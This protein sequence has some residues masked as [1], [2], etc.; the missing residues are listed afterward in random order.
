MKKHISLLV[1]LFFTIFSFSQETDNSDWEAHFA[2]VDFVDIEVSDENVY[3][4]AAN[5]VFA[6][7]IETETNTEYTTVDGLSGE[8]ITAI[9]YNS[10]TSTIIIGY[11]NG[12]LQLVN[13]V[14]GNVDTFVDIRE[15]P[16]PAENLKIN[17][18]F[19]E[20]NTLYIASGFGVIIFNLDTGFF[21]NT[22]LISDSSDIISDV[23]SVGVIDNNILVS[24]EGEGTF[25]GDTNNQNLI[26]FDNWS[27]I[28][29][30]VF[31]DIQNFSNNLVAHN[32][33][34]DLFS[35]DGTVFSIEYINSLPILNLEINSSNELTITDA[36]N[37][38]VIDND[39]EELL[40]V[41][42][43]EDL[44][45]DNS[46]FLDNV[47]YF[48]TADTGFNRTA[49]ISFDTFSKI[50]PDGPESNRA[51]AIDAFNN[52]LW[53]TFGDVSSTF[54]VGSLTRTGISRKEGQNWVGFSFE[55]VL[56]VS[57]ITG[58]VIDKNREDHVYF[59]S[60]FGGLLEFNEEDFTLYNSEN[61][62]I[63][64]DVSIDIFPNFQPVRIDKVF[65]STIDD[66][67]NVW[68]LNSRTT[69]PIK[70]FS[71]N[72]N[73]LEVDYSSVV[74]FEA[75]DRDISLN[76]WDIVVSDDGNVFAGSFDRGLIAYN[77][78]RSQIISLNEIEQN[79]IPFVTVR[80][81]ELD[82]NGE[83]WFGTNLGLRR[84]VNP[85][86]IFINGESS[87]A[88]SIIF[89]ENGIA[90]ELLIGQLI[91]DIEVDVNN[92]K[93]I[94]T[95]EGGAFYVS[96]DGQ[97]TIFNFTEANSPLPSNE[98]NDI[99]VD[100]V[101]GSV[102]FA[103]NRGL[104][105]FKTNIVSAEEDLSSIKVFPNPVKPDT[106]S[107]NV[108][109]EGLTAGANVKITDVEGNLVFETQ[110]ETFGDG[111]SGT[112]LWDTR[113]FNGSKVSSGVYFILITGAD[114]VE[115]GVEKLL[116]VR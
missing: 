29:T 69:N 105:E 21:G 97:E 23:L 83:L 108:N 20:G 1:F 19:I 45:I 71:T 41:E 114:G 89:L 50:S 77:I 86:S 92:N 33:T 85:N 48:S 59:S 4:A 51:D 90:Q 91:T 40:N 32:N 74:N 106:Q 24:I 66:N 104:V 43:R 98:V 101:T 12:L 116:I 18:F 94:A 93:W 95:S 5:S 26:L 8:D 110:N 113:S 67:G 46:V 58:V 76:L 87:V 103:T 99:A 9:E 73:G 14:T 57:D 100:D 35:F 111:G 53:I 16:F 78:E 27:L 34:V 60:F 54:T 81:V 17:N 25:L 96:A 102:F 13:E 31:S 55:D 11:E 42:H 80:A 79:N 115:T 10:L 68:I 56:E 70:R 28:Q 88:E 109:I 64:K 112:V 84:F 36:E 82:L 7:N 63:D 72:G 38:V 75:G 3:V 2:Y 39:F 6:Y 107:L 22:Y 65:S 44:N 30:D 47:F 49:N 61:S 52:D 62:N 37:S 15:Q